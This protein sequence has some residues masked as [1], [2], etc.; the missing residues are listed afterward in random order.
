MFEEFK[1][2]IMRGNV[3]DL[4]VGVII[5]VAFGAVVSSLVEDIIMPPIGLLLGGLDFSAL[6]LVLQPGAVPPPYSTPAAAREA[7]AVTLN[8]GQF[9]NTIIT[10]LVVAFAVFMMVRV[11]NRLYVAKTDEAAE[12]EPVVKECPFCITEIP[13]MATRCPHCTSDLDLAPQA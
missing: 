9:I 8:Y 7:G 11:V 5:G 13:V 2:F 3:L 1:K 4:A 6:M 10:F 12:A